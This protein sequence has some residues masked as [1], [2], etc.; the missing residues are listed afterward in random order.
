MS[1]SSKSPDTLKHLIP[2]ALE[3]RN[4]AN[5]FTETQELIISEMLTMNQDNRIMETKVNQLEGRLGNIHT[6][7]IVTNEKNKFL[8][9]EVE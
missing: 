3:L 6:N 2:I 4:F 9:G 8:N 7:D 1:A 5:L